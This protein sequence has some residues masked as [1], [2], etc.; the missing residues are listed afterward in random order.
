MDTF[1]RFSLY[2]INREGKFPFNPEEYSK[3]KFGCKSIAR[4]YGLEL[5][6]KF[7]WN[8]IL[9]GKLAGKKIVVLSSPYCFIPTATFAMKNYFVQELNQWLIKSGGDVVEEVKINRTITYKE[10]YG[11]LNAD[12]RL[13]LIQNDGFQFDTEAIKDKVLILLDDIRI[14]GSHEKVIE[15]M[16][17]S[18][19]LENN[20]IYVYFAMLDNPLIDPKVENVLNYAY[21]KNLDDLD[22]IIKNDNFLLNTRVI[23]YILGYDHEEFKVFINHQKIVTVESIYHLAIGN[24]YHKIEDYSKN[25]EYIRDKLGY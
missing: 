10:D 24:S 20:R 14:T 2:K 21:V 11:E 15:R 8:Y 3:F 16:V 5:A 18:Y 12:Q 23:K 7:A 22:S 25:L 17:Q 6:K 1:E 4:E 19:G 13:S 9:S